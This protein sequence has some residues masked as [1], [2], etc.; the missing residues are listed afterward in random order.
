MNERERIKAVVADLGVPSMLNGSGVM[1]MHGMDRVPEDLDFFVPTAHW[2]E[3][4]HDGRWDVLCTEPDDAKQR[5]D[6]PILTAKMYSIE[7]NVFS[8]W[9]IRDRGNAD[10]NLEWKRSEIVDGVRCLSLKRLQEWKA[11]Q[12]REKDVPDV[13]LIAAHLAR[14]SA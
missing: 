6:P 12:L 4:Y 9:R 5:F 1:V 3:L 8:A 13:D 7:V 11:E 14:R 2:L 10:L